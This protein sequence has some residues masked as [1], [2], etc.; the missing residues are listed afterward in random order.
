[1]SCPKNV[2][3][4]INLEKLSSAMF[5]SENKSSG[6]GKNERGFYISFYTYRCAEKQ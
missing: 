4:L 6:G 2:K 3:I 5:I 1:M